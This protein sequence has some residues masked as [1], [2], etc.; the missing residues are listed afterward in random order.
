[1][2]NINREESEYIVAKEIFLTNQLVFYFQRNHFLTEKF[3]DVIGTFQE[4]GFI[5]RYMF[6]Y[7]DFKLLK[8]R[9]RGKIRSPM[10]LNQLL[11]VFQVYFLGILLSTLVFLAEICWISVVEG[12]KCSCARKK[13]RII[14]P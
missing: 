5:K 12:F 8:S 2:N 9:K 6:K 7:V 4:A 3:T 11:S 10:S 13:Q 14:K 1:M